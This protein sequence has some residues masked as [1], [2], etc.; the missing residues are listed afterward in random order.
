MAHNAFNNLTSYIESNV[1]LQT[2]VDFNN[3]VVM[4]IMVY[5]ESIVLRHT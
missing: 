1:I 2:Y 3:S 4:S 5:G